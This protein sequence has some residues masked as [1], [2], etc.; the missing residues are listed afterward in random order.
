MEHKPVASIDEFLKNMKNYRKRLKMTQTDMTKL[1]GVSQSTIC[2]WE[3][4]T[5]DIGLVEAINVAQILSK[6]I[7]DKQNYFKCLK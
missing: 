5:K 7:F 4:G 2:N 3:K 1:L 6:D